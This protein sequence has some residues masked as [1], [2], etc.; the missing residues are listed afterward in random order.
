ME[1][2]TASC[3]LSVV[4]VGS[5]HILRVTRH[6]IIRHTKRSEVEL[7]EGIFYSNFKL[8]FSNTSQTSQCYMK[9]LLVIESLKICHYCYGHHYC[10]YCLTLILFKHYIIVSAIRCITDPRFLERLCSCLMFHRFPCFIHPFPNLW[11][12]WSVHLCCW[13]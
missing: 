4:Y 1:Y 10:W 2:G 7:R 5:Y 8:K 9:F 3:R 11:Y 6:Q 13:F 12:D